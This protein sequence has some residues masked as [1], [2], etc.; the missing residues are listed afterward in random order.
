[1]TLILETVEEKS[2]T[3][4]YVRGPRRA[5]RGLKIGDKISATCRD[6]LVT[7]K[8]ID[9][10]SIS[11]YRANGVST[12]YESST[13]TL[14]ARW[15]VRT[16]GFEVPHAITGELQKNNEST[17]L[18]ETPPRS[19]HKWRPGIPSPSEPSHQTESVQKILTPENGIEKP[20][21]GNLFD[22]RITLAIAR[23]RINA[24]VSAGVA[25]LRVDEK[26]FLQ[27]R[28]DVD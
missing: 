7:I 10:A 14:S 28:A 13:G 8:K 22:D 27:I 5:W 25:E 16:C 1:M 24:A 3:R 20:Y 21:Q 23:K 15:S 19:T 4:V 17:F 12:I 9:P 2:A 11:G 6:G 18:I 26:G